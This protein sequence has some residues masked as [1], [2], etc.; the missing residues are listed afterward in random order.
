MF[1]ILHCFICRLSDSTVSED[2]GIKPRTVATLALAVLCS[3]HSAILSTIRLDLI[4]TLLDLIHTQLDLIHTRL[5]LIHLS[6]ISSTKARSHPAS[7][8][9]HP[10][11]A[12]SHPYSARFHPQ[13]KLK[14]NFSQTSLP[15]YCIYS[16]NSSK[17]NENTQNILQK[18]I[19]TI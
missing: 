19:P 11:L 5:D 8:R 17:R 18:A 7:A 13:L 4:H 3:N 14:L 6:K 12:R 15:V 16:Q 1:F 10:L 9:S 2:A